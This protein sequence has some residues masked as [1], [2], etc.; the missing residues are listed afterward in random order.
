MISHDAHEY[1]IITLSQI[2]PFLVTSK[3][4]KVFVY[5]Y[6][7]PMI[8]TYYK[9][10]G[11]Y[12]ANTKDK[13]ICHPELLS[14]YSINELIYIYEVLGLSEKYINRRELETIIYKAL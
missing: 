6:N 4:K 13:Y 10:N 14:K 1:I 5:A 2:L 9:C 11:Y 3:W 8:L 12:F 7:H